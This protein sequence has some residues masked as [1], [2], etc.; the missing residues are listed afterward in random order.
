MSRTANPT[1]P[2]PSGAG[3]DV[4]AVH[5]APAPTGGRSRAT[6]LRR[7]LSVIA[8]LVVA[9]FLLGV[10]V[11]RVGADA[12]LSDPVAG[13]D[14]VAPG[15]SLWDV[16]ARTAP[17]GADTREHLERIRGMNDVGGGHVDAWTVVAIPAR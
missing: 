6:Y 7:R 8:V 15:E 10:M 3:V 9:V 13:H 14:V 12:G 11:G 2:R 5:G 17:P 16:A 4:R 1:R